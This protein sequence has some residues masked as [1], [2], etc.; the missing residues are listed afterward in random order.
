M[1]QTNEVL[2][3]TA[4]FKIAM[5]YK[6]IFRNRM[7]LH[8]YKKLNQSPMPEPRPALKFVPMMIKNTF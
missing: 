6:G 2:T 5:L 8:K 3:N 4:L 1:Y 7:E